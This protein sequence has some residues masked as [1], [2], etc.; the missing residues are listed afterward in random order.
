MPYMLEMLP[1]FILKGFFQR[2]YVKWYCGIGVSELQ[3]NHSI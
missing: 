3:L 2:F 1:F